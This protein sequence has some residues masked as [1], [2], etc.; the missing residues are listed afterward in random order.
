MQENDFDDVATMICG[1]CR[2]DLTDKGFEA[3]RRHVNR[4]CETQ[5]ELHREQMEAEGADVMCGG[6]PGGWCVFDFEPVG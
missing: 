2:R 3:R 1:I 5:A 4:C 6:Q